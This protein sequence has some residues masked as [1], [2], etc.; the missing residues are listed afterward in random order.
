MKKL[1]E[2]IKTRET[3]D[4]FALKQNQS[5]KESNEY[6]KRQIEDLESEH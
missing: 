1:V 2:E 5:M 3:T 4:T 6:L